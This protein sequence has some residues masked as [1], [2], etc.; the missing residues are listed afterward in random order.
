MIMNILHDK[1]LRFISF[2]IKILEQE[3]NK[4]YKYNL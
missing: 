2:I 1:E 4:I 3:L